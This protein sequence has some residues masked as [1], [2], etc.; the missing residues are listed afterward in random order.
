MNKNVI[1][2]NWRELKG[3]IQRQWGELTDSDIDKMEGD[4]EALKGALQKTYGYEQEKAEQEIEQFVK[5]NKL[6]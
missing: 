1:K 3:K 2:G 6:N 5:D 4:Y